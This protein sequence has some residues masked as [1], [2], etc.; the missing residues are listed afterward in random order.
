MDPRGN[1]KHPQETDRLQPGLCP[2]WDAAGRFCMLVD[3]GLYIP[4]KRHVSFYCQSSHHPSCYQYQQLTGA[5]DTVHP[6]TTLP[7]NRRRSNRVPSHHSFR[8]SQITEQGQLQYGQEQAALTLDLS[9][10]GLSCASL[11]QLPPETSIR[12][13]LDTDATGA[14]AEGIGRVI[15]SHP[16]GNKTFFHSGIAFSSLYHPAARHDRSPST[17]RPRP[18]SG[19]GHR[20]GK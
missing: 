7:N 6:K 9:E 20:L 11:A 19:G 4:L 8:F 14:P 1:T 17:T 3:D 12:F 18:P 10:H 2:Y 13:F 5:T 16:I 15:W